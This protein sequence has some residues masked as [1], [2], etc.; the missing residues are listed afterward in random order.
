MDLTT[1]ENIKSLIYT[2][3]GE[4]VML[5][6][7]LSI[8]Y[9]VETK[10]LN[11]TVKRNILRFPIEFRFRL[12]KEEVDLILSQLTV[13]NEKSLK[14]QFATSNKGRGG[15]RKLPYVFT[16]QGVAMLSA[17]LRSKKSIS[18]RLTLDIK[19][20]NEQHGQLDCEELNNIHDRFI[21]IDEKEIYHSGASFKDLGKKISAFSKLEKES[22]KLLGKI[23]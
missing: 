9:E 4:Q 12:T 22:I 16:E 21:I 17:V 1:N 10:R 13:L 7:D 6:S 19:K 20:F 23:K 14:S 8:I 15:R 3:R 5:D 2:I 11:E 18:K